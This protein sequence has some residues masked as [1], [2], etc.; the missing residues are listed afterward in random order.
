[1]RGVDCLRGTPCCCGMQL[2]GT[3]LYMLTLLSNGSIVQ[4]AADAGR[5]V[6]LLNLTHTD[7]CFGTIVIRT[8][9][10]RKKSSTTFFL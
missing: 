3:L 5:N 10:T 2:Y 4:R 1:M 6:L 8:D 7:V 9:H